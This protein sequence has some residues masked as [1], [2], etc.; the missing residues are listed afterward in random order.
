M[1]IGSEALVPH[2][3]GDHGHRHLAGGGAIAA[4]DQA[5]DDGAIQS[6]DAEE[7]AGDG[8]ADAAA[9]IVIAD[10]RGEVAECGQLAHGAGLV[11]EVQVFL[12][13]DAA[14]NALQA[15]NG[16]DA[17]EGF[18]VLVDM[19]PDHHAVDHG[20][21][22]GIDPDADGEGEDH[23]QGEQRIAADDAAA[24]AHIFPE[25]GQENGGVPPVFGDLLFPGLRQ[26]AAGRD[27]SGGEH[28]GRPLRR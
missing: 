13:G 21:D 4:I 3:L 12:I 6:I 14:G 26:E 5:A 25:G 20:K 15:R 2:F 7:V 9:S 8:D 19:R 24:V 1:G 23:H 10:Q 11:A 17:Y 28:F 16:N 18:R 27:H 22:A